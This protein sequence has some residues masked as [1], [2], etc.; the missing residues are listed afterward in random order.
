MYLISMYGG[1]KINAEHYDYYNFFV[2]L[3]KII[4]Q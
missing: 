4:V 3:T 1:A 2:L